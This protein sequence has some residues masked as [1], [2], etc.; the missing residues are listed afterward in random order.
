[1]QN[2]ALKNAVQTG[3]IR[4]VLDIRRHESW[5][6]YGAKLILLGCIY[7]V[8]ARFGLSLAVTTEQVSTIWPATGVAMAAML[9]MG[10]R[11]WPG[12]FI[13][14]LIANA[15]THEPLLV[16]SAIATGN[17]LEAVVGA[18]LIQ[19]FFP[20]KQILDSMMSLIGF[21]CLAAILSTV[22][23]AT[24]G[25]VSLILG[26]LVQVEH[27]GRIW[28]AWWVGDMMGALVILPF[29]ASWSNDKYRIPLKRRPL[30]AGLLVTLSLA[31]SLLI[32]IQPEHNDTIAWPLTYLAFPIIAWAA[33]RFR[34]IGV[35]TAGIVISVAAIWGT[36]KELGPFTVSQ[37]IE[38]NIMVS[39]FFTMIVITTGL[40]LS[41]AIYQRKRT[42][43]ALDEQYDQLEKSKSHNL[44]IIK[45]RQELED[46][47]KTAETRIND[48]LSGVLDEN[49]TKKK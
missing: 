20:D 26:G 8:L 37:S 27:F 29:I 14:A 19:R 17:T 41:I 21:I 30:E 4:G 9:L 7:V 24:I 47:I 23:S 43:A 6:Q 46:Q 28:Q 48:I 33:V 25:V 11:Y 45:L 38:Q 5:E 12:I 13:G 32:F 18:Y 42:E 22:I 44:Q 40:I 2:N 35:V 15:I 49:E 31:I 39:H 16:A 34:Q 3:V 36:L 1:M 10:Y